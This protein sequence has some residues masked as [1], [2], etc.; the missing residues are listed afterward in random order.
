MCLSLSV[1]FSVLDHLTA[2]TAL[3]PAL[4]F[5]GPAELLIHNIQALEPTHVRARRAARPPATLSGALSA[6][7][8]R[9]A[10]AVRPRRLARRWRPPLAGD[11]PRSLGVARWRL[12][13]LPAQ[14][15][16]E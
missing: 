13:H 7:C 11:G 4:T 1:G 14:A 9:D 2:S 15:G 5:H 6:A 12:T 10:T 3:R 16:E 8:G